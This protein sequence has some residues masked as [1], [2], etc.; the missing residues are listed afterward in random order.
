MNFIKKS[1]LPLKKVK[2]IAIDSRAEEIID[3]ELK[4]LGIKA[5][6][7]PCDN[8]LPKPIS[9]HTDIH[10]FHLENGVFFTSDFFHE[11]F[12]REIISLINKKDC[13][14]FNNRQVTEKLGRE[15]PHDVALNAVNVGDY[16]ICNTKT[17]SKDILGI[18]TK[19]IIEVNQG[20]TKCSVSVV[21]DDAVITDDPSIFKAVK[22]KIDVLLTEHQ[23]V[24]LDG[25]NYGFIGGCSGKISKD[26]LAFCG[27]INTHKQSEDI[28]AFCKNHG[29]FCTS[30]SNGNLYDYGSLIPIIEE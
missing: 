4:Q 3:N 30:L 29:V 7:V 6:T 16:L 22:N 5:I 11:V 24:L 15:Y 14:F 13:D 28:K 23:N 18:N 21:S 17:I 12:S 8:T 20:Y 10:L 26:T 25:Y 2:Y 9:G 19:E 1:N 27:N